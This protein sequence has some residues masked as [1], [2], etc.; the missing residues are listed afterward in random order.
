M[1]NKKV[2]LGSLA[3][4]CLVL[5]LGVALFFAGLF[6]TKTV[7]YEGI[8]DVYIEYVWES[9]YTIP[10][11][12]VTYWNYY[13]Y[14]TKLD[15]Q[16]VSKPSLINDKQ[17]ENE[18]FVEEFDNFIKNELDDQIEGKGLKYG[19]KTDMTLKN[20][21]IN[22]HS[23]QNTRGM[24]PYHGGTMDIMDG[25]YTFDEFSE[26]PMTYNE[27]ISFNR[28][29]TIDVFN[30]EYIFIEDNNLG[31]P[32]DVYDLGVGDTV[33]Y[34]GMDTVEE[35][36]KTYLNNNFTEINF[37]M[38]IVEVIL[39]TIFIIVSIAGLVFVLI[40]GLTKKEE[41]TEQQKRA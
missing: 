10:S 38:Q 11:S 31:N 30:G 25:F 7:Q 13:I 6:T 14:E 19:F 17:N 12:G 29:G 41:K 40:K 34:S 5:V 35:T 22:E 26:Y 1:K 20:F 39:G 4:M 15:L 37:T 32:D 24:R 23:L 21:V 27:F 2:F 16:M 36:T 3:T 18:S 8:N 9:K 33:N 28:E